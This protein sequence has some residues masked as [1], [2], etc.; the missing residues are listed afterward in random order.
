MARPEYPG[1]Q[2]DSPHARIYHRHLPHPAWKHLSGNAFKL[3]AYL[4]AMYRP[5]EPNAIAA[6]GKR[7]GELI[8]VSPSTATRC[9]DELIASGHLREERRGRNSGRVQT[10]ERVVSLTRHD[11]ET[12]KGDPDLPTKRW[13]S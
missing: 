11:T 12:A 5:S 6:G 7:I 3:L 8:N 2:H 9:V 4:L 10:R 1:S 13:R